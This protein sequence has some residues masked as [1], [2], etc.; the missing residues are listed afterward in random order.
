M[1]RILSRLDRRHVFIASMLV[2]FVVVRVWLHMRPDTDLSVGGYNIHHLFTGVLIL[3]VFAIPAMLRPRPETR[4]TS[5]GQAPSTSSGQARS[6]SSGQAR[7][8]SSGQAGGCVTIAGVGVGLSL[9]LDE[10]FYLIV[11]DGSNAAYVQWPSLVGGAIAVGV[12]CLYALVWP[13]EKPD[14]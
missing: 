13:A 10:W 1:G 7:S 6:T 2:T 8:T 12:A 14:I 5:S 11:T 3:S 4:S 9:V